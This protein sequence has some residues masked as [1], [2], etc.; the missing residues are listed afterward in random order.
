MFTKGTLWWPLVLRTSRRAM[1]SLCGD[2]SW[3]LN[4]VNAQSRDTLTASHHP[5]SIQQLI[6]LF[7]QHSHAAFFIPLHCL[8]PH[9]C[10]PSSRVSF[11]QLKGESGN[12]RPRQLNRIRLKQKGMPSAKDIIFVMWHKQRPFMI[13]WIN[14]WPTECYVTPWAV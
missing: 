8:H 6:T 5:R 12:L 1:Q 7:T 10:L 11:P 2:G 9:W 3:S 14:V 4:M 13:S